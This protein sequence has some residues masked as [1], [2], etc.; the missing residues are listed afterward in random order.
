MH[1]LNRMIGDPPEHMAEVIL[2]IEAI[3]FCGFDQRI[4]GCRRIDRSAALLSMQSLPSRNIKVNA[5]QRDS[6]RLVLHYYAFDGSSANS[7]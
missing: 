7:L 4:C 2:R 5:C 6:A 1:A 3:Q